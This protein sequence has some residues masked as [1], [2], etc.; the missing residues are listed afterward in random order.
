MPK[1]PKFRANLRLT[2]DLGSGRQGRAPA[3]ESLSVPTARFGHVVTPRL[4]LRTG[5]ASRITAPKLS[6]REQRDYVRVCDLGLTYRYP[7]SSQ[8]I[9]KALYSNWLGRKNNTRLSHIRV[10]SFSL[11]SE[12]GIYST[13]DDMF[14]DFTWS[15][16]TPQPAPSSRAGAPSESPEE[17]MPSWVTLC[18]NHQ[19][20]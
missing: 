2:V 3:G 7:T 20:S 16:V 10:D 11:G 14:Q 17:D 6:C 15:R 19:M 5:P 18:Y 9:H 12:K 4:T 8:A 1:T 13:S